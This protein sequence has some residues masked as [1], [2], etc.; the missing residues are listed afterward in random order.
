MKQEPCKY[1]VL[2]IEEDPSDGLVCQ[3]DGARHYGNLYCDKIVPKTDIHER[4]ARIREHNNY[5]NSLPDEEL[6]RYMS[7][8]VNH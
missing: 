8:A 2:G 4:A 6:V 1:C 7:L 5:L 3:I